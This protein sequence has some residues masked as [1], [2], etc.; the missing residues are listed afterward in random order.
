MHAQVAIASNALDTASL[1]PD[2]ALTIHRVFMDRLQAH[3]RLVFADDMDARNLLRA[4]TSGPGLPP[5]ARVW[6][7]EVLATFAKNNR[8]SVRQP[9]TTPLVQVAT[10]AELYRHW[11]DSVDVA[12]IA[13]AASAA[14]GV[15]A[16]TGFLASPG[17]GPD[18]VTAHSAPTSPA[19]ERLK[20][21]ADK[22]TL[23][24]TSRRETFRQDVLTP[25]AAGAQ[26]ATIVDRYYFNRVWRPDDDKNAP[27]HVEWL[28]GALDAVMAPGAKVHIIAES[29]R[30]VSATDTAAAVHTAWNP[31]NTGRLGEAVLSLIA[32]T[33]P[34]RVPHD[35]HIRFSTGAAVLMPSGFDRLEKPT[36]ADPNGMNWHYCWGPTKLADL[37]AAEQR[38]I[39]LP[40]GRATILQRP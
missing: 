33:A 40:H 29:Q 6:W 11:N 36:V 13:T 7:G 12:V 28:L 8:V 37:R 27:G 20:D 24:H 17:H 22:G 9:S 31:P 1:P 34:A 30:N 2:A 16:A 32:R 21:L 3:G 5:Q 15:P 25:L 19:I 38:T 35:R 4:V 26:T 10:L 23:T 14:L 18:V 39:A